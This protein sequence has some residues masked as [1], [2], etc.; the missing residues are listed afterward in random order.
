[1][2]IPIVTGVQNERI[3]LQKSSHILLENV[4]FEAYLPRLWS[5]V[6]Q[7]LALYSEYLL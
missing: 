7:L 6:C 2:R 1:M 3:N 5:L 4:I